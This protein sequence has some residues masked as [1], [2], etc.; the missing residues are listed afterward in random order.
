MKRLSLAF[1]LLLAACA[2]DKPARPDASGDTGGNSAPMLRIVADADANDRRPVAVDVVRVADEGLAHRLGMLDAA[3]WFRDRSIL[4]GEAA[5]RIAIA[6][7]EMV[8]G[9][10]VILRSLPPFAATPSSTLVF[11]RYGT[12]G[13]HRRSLD[14]AGGLDIRLG[15]DGFSL[16]PLAKDAAP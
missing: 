5:G 12:P 8:P 7:W 13:A 6:S 1:A 9:Q 2:A 14:G 16:A 4:N 11:A 10:S 3:G 15:R